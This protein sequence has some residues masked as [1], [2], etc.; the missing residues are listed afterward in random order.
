MLFRSEHLH[1]IRGVS[2]VSDPHLNHRKDQEALGI[3]RSKFLET[4]LRSILTIELNITE[5]CNRK[6][7]FC[8]RVD[9]EVYPNQNLNMDQSVVEAVVSNVSKLGIFPRF[10]FSGFG[11]PVL[12]KRLAELIRIIRT[13]LPDHTIEINTNGDR[14]KDRKTHV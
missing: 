11:E 12:H 10:S 7:V 4:P 9:P 13:V 14:L 2:A 8:P 6:C 5:L 3:E 1:E